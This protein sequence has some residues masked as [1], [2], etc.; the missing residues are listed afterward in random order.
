[1][2][3]VLPEVEATQRILLQELV[4][5][6]RVEVVNIILRHQGQVAILLVLLQDRVDIVQLEVVSMM[7]LLRD[8]PGMLQSLL[9]EQVVTIQLAVVVITLQQLEVVNTT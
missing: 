4:N 6:I 9:H 2:T 5:I 3:I 7:L 8:R 1:M